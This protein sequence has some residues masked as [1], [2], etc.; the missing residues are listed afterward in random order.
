MDKLDQYKRLRD[1][2]TPELEFYTLINLCVS[3]YEINLI[4]FNMTH[5]Q[6]YKDIATALEKFLDQFINTDFI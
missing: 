3:R 6:K 5:Q 1:S 4:K 2:I